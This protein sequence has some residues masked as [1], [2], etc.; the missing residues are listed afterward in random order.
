MYEDISV[1]SAKVLEEGWFDY[2]KHIKIKK[3][4]FGNEVLITPIRGGHTFL[5]VGP[6][7]MFL[8]SI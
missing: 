1:L 8:S 2:F 6:T 4:G 3:F 5:P 7:R